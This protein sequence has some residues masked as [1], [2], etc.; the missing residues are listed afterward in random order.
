MK[1]ILPSIISV[2]SIILYYQINH[3]TNSQLIY[4][5]TKIETISTFDLLEYQ[6]YNRFVEKLNSENLLRSSL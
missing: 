6:L 5:K 1:V 2:I 4:A 3:K